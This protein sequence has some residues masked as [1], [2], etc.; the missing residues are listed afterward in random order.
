MCLIQEIPESK[1][2]TRNKKCM[3]LFFIKHVMVHYNT[4]KYR[5]TIL[6]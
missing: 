2:T 1:H 3:N 5:S 4:M 6:A